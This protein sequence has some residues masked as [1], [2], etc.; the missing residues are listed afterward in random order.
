MKQID[1]YVLR[2]FF[3]FYL[4]ASLASV[5]IFVTVDLIEHLDKFIDAR[6]GYGIVIHYYYLYL[7]YIFYLTLP[8]AVLL[9]TLFTVGGFV[10]RNEMTAMQSAGYSLWRIL[11]LHMLV[12]VPLSAASFVVG[13][14]VVPAANHERKDIYRDQIRKQRDPASTRQGRLYIQVGPH[15]YLKMETY[16]PVEKLG[17]RVS[18]ETFADS[19][20][21]RRL[22][23]RQMQYTDNVWVL[24]NVWER[25]MTGEQTVI[26]EM[27]SIAR[28][29][30]SVTPDDLRRVHIEP[31]EMN[32]VDLRNLVRRLQA[33]GI[34]AGKWM[35]D[36]AFKVS[37]PFATAVIV[38]FGVPFAAFRRR[39]GLVFGFGLS[40]L[41]CFIYF[42]FI[43]IGKILGYHGTVGPYEAAWAGNVV[44]G[45]LGF[46]LV[47]RAPK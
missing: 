30:I 27:D 37:Q 31:E 8:V 39:G 9:A 7:P 24:R 4:F 19:R 44:F 10:N 15:E 36:L 34:R 2:T 21:V 45:L 13:E 29:D 11:F 5:V 26:S 43:Q 42:G 22:E 33:S 28:T 17:Q 12:A 32:Y 35:V 16:D 46:I 6:L 3:Q 20:L 1:R 23:A 18:L 41:V 47:W 25:R 38:L 40:L 14:T